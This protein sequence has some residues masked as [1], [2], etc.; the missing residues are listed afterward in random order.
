[1]SFSLW[2]LVDFSD[3]LTDG[4]PEI[5]DL[6]PLYQLLGFP[7]LPESAWPDCGI[8]G[9][10]PGC[11][12]QRQCPSLLILILTRSPRSN[13]ASELL[14]NMKEIHPVS[15]PFLRPIY[16]SH[17]FTILS[18]ALQ[19]A[20]G[21]NYTQLLDTLILNPLNLRN[22]GVSPGDDE[23]AVIPPVQNSWGSDYGDNAPC[24]FISH[25][26]ATFTNSFQVAAVSSPRLA[27][28]QHSF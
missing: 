13:F 8:I 24:V 14:E 7:E 4:Y 25:E 26:P 2:F 5:Y 18:Y 9:L 6:V 15:A 3:A 21:Q 12:R 11:T 27:T 17:S 23:K 1:M 20:T 19:N 10:N 28:Y 16:S 22:T